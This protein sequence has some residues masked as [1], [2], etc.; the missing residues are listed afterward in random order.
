MKKVIA[1]LATMIVL[2][3]AVFAATT[4]AS[5]T[6]TATIE[7]VQPTFTI[8]GAVIANATATPGT[9]TLSTSTNTIPT[10]KN[11]ATEDIYIAI[12]VF[13]N[14]VSFYKDESGFD[15]TVTATALC[16]NTTNRENATADEKTDNP[17][18]VSSGA[19]ADV[20]HTPTGGTEVIDFHPTVSS[21]T[22][23]V[24]T[25]HV[26]YPSGVKINGNAAENSTAAKVG[27]AVFKW[28]AKD[29]L[30]LGSYTGT[31]TLSYEAN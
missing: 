26:T 14:N 30:V 7:K 11:I 5:L 18:I 19:G 28:G 29:T 23:S 6:I 9:Y 3:G 25:Y 4:D 20:K 27:T 15:L 22:G 1:I 24:V 17:T 10:G 12:T 2:V 31:I 21:A 16:L 8:G 13:Q